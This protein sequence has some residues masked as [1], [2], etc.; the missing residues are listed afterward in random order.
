MVDKQ[1]LNDLLSGG[2][3]VKVDFYST[4][5][6]F[7]IEKDGTTYTFD[8]EL[9]RDYGNVIILPKLTKSVVVEEKIDL[10]V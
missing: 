10:E 9:Y 6:R 7:V 8:G 1:K 5:V 3:V 2:K 4:I